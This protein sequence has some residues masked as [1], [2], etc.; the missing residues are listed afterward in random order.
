MQVIFNFM[1]IMSL[2]QEKWEDRVMDVVFV[3]L[4]DAGIVNDSQIFHEFGLWIEIL[5]FNNESRKIICLGIYFQK[6]A[7][8]LGSI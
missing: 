1:L 5:S 6:K 7:Y 3:G 8:I 4:L 2:M